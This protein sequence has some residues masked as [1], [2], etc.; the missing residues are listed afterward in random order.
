MA[1]LDGPA[2]AAAVAVGADAAAASGFGAG[3]ASAFSTSALTMR[4]CGPEPLMAPRSRP[5]CAAIRRARGVA[6]MRLPS[7]PCGAAGAG[8]AAAAGAGASAAGASGAAAGAGAGA[9]PMSSALSPSS[10]STAMAVLTLTPS[11]PSA[12][13]ILPTKPSSTASNSIVALSVSIS[14]MI[15]PDDTL[16]PSLT[17]HLASV[18][19]SIVGDRAGIRISVAMLRL[20]LTRKYLSKARR[21]PVRGSLWR[22]RRWR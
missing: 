13:R 7:V 12:T 18:P 22:T 10:S 11:V 5:F 1:S 2:G 21:G 19:S 20:S 15:S 17:S 16:S 3:A 6:K 14:A 9:A 8:V 4:P